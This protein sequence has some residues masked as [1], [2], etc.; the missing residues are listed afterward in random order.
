MSDFGSQLKGVSGSQ[1]ATAAIYAGA[2][3]LIVSDVIPT[4]ADA[5]YFWLERK[6]RDQWK[7]GK[8]TPSQYWTREAIIY[9][10]LNPLWW[11]LV[12]VLIVRAK[13]DAS[14]KLKILLAIIGGGAVIGVIFKNVQ[15]DTAELAAEQALIPKQ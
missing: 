15:L 8:I 13:G 7:Q 2:I 9:Y 1:Y 14:H 3:G 11:L 12:L 4:P 6:L 5:L 10:G